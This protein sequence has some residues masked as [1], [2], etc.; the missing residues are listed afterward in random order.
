MKNLCQMKKQFNF[1]KEK[2]AQCF[3]IKISESL[4]NNKLM[5]ALKNQIVVRIKI[6]LILQLISRIITKVNLVGK[7]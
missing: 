1:E 4:I 5:K 7:Q 6:L 3:E 2:L